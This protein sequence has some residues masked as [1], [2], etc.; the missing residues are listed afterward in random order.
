MA[1]VQLRARA[2]LMTILAK[3]STKKEPLTVVTAAKKAEQART[4]ASEA[5]PKD[6]GYC[7]HSR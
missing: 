6:Y 2:P 7:E 3:Y 5:D 4:F 1:M